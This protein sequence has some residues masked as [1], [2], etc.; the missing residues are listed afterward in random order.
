MRKA[1]KAKSES[2]E[3]VDVKG[4][5]EKAVVLKNVDQRKKELEI[6][7]QF[8][9]NYK[10]GPAYGKLASLFLSLSRLDLHIYFE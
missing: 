7:K 1:R 6:L 8:D 3:K 2:S 4:V 5:Y 10:F 9:L